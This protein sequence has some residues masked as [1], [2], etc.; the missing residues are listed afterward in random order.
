MTTL[1]WLVAVDDSIW[2]SY[3]FNFAVQHLNKENDH[4]YLMHV[5]EAPTR[6]F[7]GYATATLI[8]SLQK[9]EDEKARKILVHYGRRAKDLGIQYSMMKGSEN[10]PGSLLCKAVE[11]YNINNMVL[12]RRGLGTIHRFFVGSTSKYCV[13]N[14]ACNVVVIKT[15]V[16]LEEENEQNVRS[17]PSEKSEHIREEEQK[18]KKA[19]LDAVIRAEEEER[20][21]R[22]AETGVMT[23]AQIDD[24][25][26][27][28]K[29]LDDIKHKAE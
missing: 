7:V 9:V 2:S 6:V 13:E 15:P 5:C 29:F 27:V 8:E 20:M 3:A 12:G 24:K 19:A 11:Q 1:N 4:L 16:G 17:I 26:K 23:K 18:E 21:R 28:Y 25:I 10:S 14:A 22:L